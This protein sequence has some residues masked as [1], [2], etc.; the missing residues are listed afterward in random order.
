MKVFQI[1]FEHDQLA[2]LEKEFFPYYNYD[3]SVYF[4]NSV[5]REL[6]E[7]GAHKRSEYFGVV[8]YKLRTKLGFT[9]DNWRNNKN[10]ANIS[11]QDFTPKQFNEQLYKGK[12][13][14]MSFQRHVPHDCITVADGF[15]PGFKKHWIELMSKIGYKW[16]PTQFQDV[17]YCNYQ[18]VKSDIYGR[19]VKELL[20]PAMD[21]MEM[22]SGLYDRC[23]YPNSLPTNLKEKWGVDHYTF[24][25]FLCERMFTYF[26]H[27]HNL[28]CLHY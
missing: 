1:Y 23:H 21:E 4:E 11:T 7:I 24:H 8:S 15:H 3:C 13:D 25:A 10:I 12:P 22:M 18:V 26:A 17:F 19:Y 6:I 27:I 14:A 28:K 5:I 2:G 16:E 9:K 20:A